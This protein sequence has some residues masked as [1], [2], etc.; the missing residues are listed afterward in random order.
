MNKAG[1]NDPC[2]C[3]SGRKFKKCCLTAAVVPGYTSGDRA[4]ALARLDH[5]V[6]RV[7]DAEDD[8]GFEEFWGEHMDWEAELAPTHRPQSQD[9]YDLWFAFDRELDGGRLVV[10]L[11][12]DRHPD[13][14]TGEH[15]FLKALRDSSM[16]LWEVLDLSPGVSVTLRDVV[17]RTEV[18]VHER[19]GSRTLQRHEWLA[20]RVVP[21][22]SSGQPEIEAGLLHIPRLIRD[23]VLAQLSSRRDA[24]RR[25]HPEA[26][27]DGFYKGL[28]PFFHDAWVTALLDPP[29]PELRN[30]DGEEMVTS[31]I[32]FDVLDVEALGQSLE[33]QAALER[34]GSLWHWSGTNARGETISLGLLTLEGKSLVLETNSVERAGRGRAL[35]ESLASGALRHRATSHENMRRRLRDAVRAR[36][37]AGADEAPPPPPDALPPEVN[38]AL[39]LD[40][41]ARHYRGWLDESIPALDGRTPRQAARDDRL[42][43]RLVDLIH[44][45]EGMYESALRSGEPAYDPSWMWR[46][47]GLDDASDPAH[48]PPL[49]HERVAALVPGS[50]ELSRAVAEEIRR[51]P[52][53]RDASTLMSVEAFSTHLA[54]QR[55]VREHDPGDGRPAGTAGQAPR[56]LAGLLHLMVNFELHRRKAFW[57]DESLAYTLD[58]TD[59]D[60]TGRELR[61]PFPSCALVFTDRHV[62]SLAERTVAAGPDGPVAGHLLRVVTVFVTE[63]ATGESRTLELAFAV[64]TLG[65]DLPHVIRHALRLEP[66][67]KVET[68][69][70]R[71]APRAAIQPAVPDARP[72]RALL[73]VAINAILYA[74]SAGI[75]PE[76]R[77]SPPGAVPARRGGVPVPYSSEEV[78]Y[79]PGAIEISQLR[80]LQELHRMPAGR[81]I[82]RRFMVRGHWR[83]APASAADPRMRWVRPYWKGPDMATIIE[84]TYKLKP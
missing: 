14:S 5:F 29:V 51:A 50:G 77:R 37:R 40:H 84:R 1:R 82:T 64:D 76:V 42:R 55:F 33:G 56:P 17:E 15:L 43:P 48:P 41:L 46:E 58:Q 68:Y 72:L 35:L 60:V 8:L 75:Q 53:F 6:D 74:T 2:P 25:D 7:M 49:A 26:P 79:L 78:Y 16:H 66:D 20:A 13:L 9:V 27:L 22:R 45:L 30:T 23:A 19:I 31:R 67:A 38:E 12:L 61:A 18:T 69:L 24:F 71:V 3:G 80:K 63:Q 36:A 39:M 62:L 10:D 73:R 28:P 34:E 52:G 54:L 11:F 44:G 59:L 83:R 32:T 21:G 81:T 47:L 65:A 57:V 70:D 4:S